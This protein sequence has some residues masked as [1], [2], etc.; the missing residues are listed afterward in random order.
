MFTFWKGKLTQR[1]NVLWDEQRNIDF[2]GRNL[3]TTLVLA[4][5]QMTILQLI[6]FLYLLIRPLN[7][8]HLPSLLRPLS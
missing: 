6:I 4:P 2:V 7:K 5:I 8:T 1:T 3:G